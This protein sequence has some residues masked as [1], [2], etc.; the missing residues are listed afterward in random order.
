MRCFSFCPP[1]FCQNDLA[2]CR[3]KMKS[4]WCN[5]IVAYP[6]VRLRWHF[7]WG[8]SLWIRKDAVTQ[9]QAFKGQTLEGT[10]LFGC[11][12]QKCLVCGQHSSFIVSFMDFEKKATYGHQK[13]GFWRTPSSNHFYNLVFEHWWD[14]TIMPR[15]TTCGVRIMQRKVPA[16]V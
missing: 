9:P 8:I 3:F 10:T 7:S 13:R 11:V 1:F 2:F 16:I 15:C 5:D 4:Y 6:S 12:Y 14:S